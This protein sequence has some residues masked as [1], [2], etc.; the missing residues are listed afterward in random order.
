MNPKASLEEVKEAIR[1]ACHDHT[2]EAPEALL[3]RLGWTS[4]EYI[5]A[6]LSGTGGPPREEK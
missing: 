4:K 1:L 2:G 3:F 6:M 5:T